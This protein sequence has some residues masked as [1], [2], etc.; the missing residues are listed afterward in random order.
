M[1][2]LLI[3]LTILVLVP[4][5]A[6]AQGGKQ[7][8]VLNTRHNLSSQSTNTTHAAAG[9]TEEVCIFCHTPH[10]AAA[11]PVYTGAQLIPLWN[12]TTTTATFTV[13]SSSTMEAAV[14]QPAGASRACLSCHDG[15]IAVGSVLYIYNGTPPITMTG[16]V[17]GA[18]QLTGAALM[19]TDLSND[20]PISFNYATH[21]TTDPSLNPATTALPANGPY[22][23]GSTVNYL[24]IGGQ[25]EC[26]SC[27]LVHGLPP[28]FVPTAPDTA[29]SFQPI[30]AASKYD[31]K[32]CTSCHIK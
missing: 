1:K 23:A 10:N 28:G 11:A 6:L 4:G 27:H 22:P 18:G 16:N 3:A 26:G 8:Q 30:L 31:S 19:G 24:L 9:Q 5:L 7:G 13:Y 14:G 2:H 21:Q 29:A 12:H 32:L 25:L 15:T 20:H 17:N